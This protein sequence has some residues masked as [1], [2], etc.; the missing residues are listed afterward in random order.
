M[1][2]ESADPGEAW[3]DS[4]TGPLLA[5]LVATQAT[6]RSM[7]SLYGEYVVPRYGLRSTTLPSASQIDLP[8]PAPRGYAA[9]LDPLTGA[10]RCDVRRDVGTASPSSLGAAGES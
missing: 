8:A 7:S 10:L 1:R 3:S 9:G 5:G 2:A 4:S 6:G